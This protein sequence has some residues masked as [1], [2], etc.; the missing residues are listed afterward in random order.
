MHDQL[1]GAVLRQPR[2]GHHVAAVFDQEVRMAHAL[3]VKPLHKTFRKGGDA[4]G[5]FG[6]FKQGSHAVAGQVGA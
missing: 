4:I 6:G 5:I 1:R 2:A 3:V